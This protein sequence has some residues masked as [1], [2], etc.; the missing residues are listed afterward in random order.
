MQMLGKFRSSGMLASCAPY[1]VDAKDNGVKD[2][3]DLIQH[4]LNSTRAL[5]LTVW[6]C[7]LGLQEHLSVN[8]DL[9]KSRTTQRKWVKSVKD[10]TDTGRETSVPHL[11]HS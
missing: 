8:R 5:L 1:A 9:T 4:L 11:V 2:T 6:R 10:S 3:Q 7:R